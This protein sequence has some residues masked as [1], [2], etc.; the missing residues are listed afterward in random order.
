MFPLTAQRRRL[1]CRALFLSLAVAPTLW[2]C[3]WA[4]A[5]NLP[6]HARGVQ[7][8]LAGSIGRHV[9]FAEI[10]HPRPGVTRLAGIHL[11]NPETG[12]W[13]AGCE[14]AVLWS[15]AIYTGLFLQIKDRPTLEEEGPVLDDGPPLAHRDLGLS[16]EQTQ[17]IIGRMM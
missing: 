12:D 9:H 7:H 17:K 8:A 10:T 13:K 11:E 1:A 16:K 6:S 2:V 15:A 5:W 3:S 14:K 4:F